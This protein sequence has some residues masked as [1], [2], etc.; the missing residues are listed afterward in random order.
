MD[1]GEGAVALCAYLQSLVGV[2]PIG[3]NVLLAAVEHQ[4]DGSMRLLR[5]GCCDDAFVA[6]AELRA[7]SAAHVLGDNAN[8]ALGQLEDVGELV[9]NAGCALGRGVDGHLFGLPIEDET[10]RFKAS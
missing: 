2:G 5:E 6:R 8:I 1:R 3:N 7:E 10:V 9:A 4:L